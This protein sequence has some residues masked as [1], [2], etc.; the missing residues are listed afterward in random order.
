[1]M[2]VHD[3][4]KQGET[5]L[6]RFK[7][8]ERDALAEQDAAH[9]AFK[10]D[11]SEANQKRG[12]HADSTVKY[13]KLAIKG[14]TERLEVVRKEVAAADAARPEIDAALE[15]TSVAAFQAEIADDAKRWAE[16]KAQLA[17]LETGL[18]ASASRFAAARK[19]GLARAFKAGLPMPAMINYEA[20]TTAVMTGDVTGSSFEQPIEAVEVCFSGAELNRVKGT[21]FQLQD[22]VRRRAYVRESGAQAQIE[23]VENEIAEVMSTL[24]AAGAD[25][26]AESISVPTSKAEALTEMNNAARSAASQAQLASD[27][28]RLAARF[29]SAPHPS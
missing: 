11:P 21:L 7:A 18:T 29:R 28:A 9:N 25:R 2:T 10:D 3:R 23:Q 19:K 13:A 16:L 4:L 26:L 12:E 17:E 15:E 8:K 20:V 22:A 27:Q 5:V 24:R 14:A 1:M 6:A